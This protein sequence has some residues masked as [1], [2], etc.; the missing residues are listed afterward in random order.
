MS[1]NENSAYE[2]AVKSNGLIV[3][4]GIAV[5]VIIA[6]NVLIFTSGNYRQRGGPAKPLALQGKPFFTPPP[7][8]KQLPAAMRRPTIVP[9]KG[10]KPEEKKAG[11]YLKLSFD[12]LAGFTYQ[13][14]HPRT[15]ADERKDQM[16]EEITKLTGKRVQV[17]GYLVPL[18]G[19]HGLATRFILCRTAPAPV[20]CPTDLV[21][22]DASLKMN[23]WIGVIME[24]GK[25]VP[26]NSRIMVT[27]YGT[28]EVS[29][30]I[31]QGRVTILYRMKAE[32][33][34]VPPEL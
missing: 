18:A 21:K 23:E 3:Y 6:L 16:P 24:D 15:N 26:V 28:L 19:R 2:G 33:V 20:C 8:V 12:R 5:A 9:V 32:D 11:E 22:M 7:K 14:P 25:G 29:E 1:V 17:E 27:V 10:E 30:K 4:G 31:V 13:P 34:Y